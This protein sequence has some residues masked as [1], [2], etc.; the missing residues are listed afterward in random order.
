M[1]HAFT[2]TRRVEFSE[3]DLAGIA[4]FANF[5]R[6]MES[7][8]HEFFRSLGLSVHGELEGREYGF[9]RVHAECDYAAPLH[10]GQLVRIDLALR[11]KTSKALTY[12]FEFRRDD[13]PAADPAARGRL[14]V[15]HVT[16]PAGAD[17]RLRATDLPA[18]IA[19]HLEVA[20]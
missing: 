18:E 16:R 1:A 3:T 10:Y 8:E 12:D 13:E 15:V 9:V 14:V 19:R 7:A 5:F 2:T 17:E 4:H 11:E 6:W 20:P